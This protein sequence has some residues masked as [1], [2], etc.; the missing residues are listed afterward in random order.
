M[1]WICKS[2][3]FH[4]KLNAFENSSVITFVPQV[5]LI[6]V[7]TAFRCPLRWTRDLQHLTYHQWNC[8]NSLLS[9]FQVFKGTLLP[10][11]QPC[12][13]LPF[14]L[15]ATEF[16]LSSVCFPFFLV[17]FLSKV[18]LC[19]CPQEITWSMKWKMVLE[20][21]PSISLTPRW[22]YFSETNIC[23]MHV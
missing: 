18:Y 23:K 1:I 13:V 20:L 10:Q 21:S 19:V 22:V 2:L 17:S 15:L 16:V 6:H 12:K 11:L 8:Y 7:Q 5:K 9:L 3:H 14:L 4:K